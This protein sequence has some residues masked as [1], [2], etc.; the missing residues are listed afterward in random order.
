MADDDVVPPRGRKSEDLPPTGWMGSDDAS[1]QVVKIHEAVRRRAVA[2]ITEFSTPT[3]LQAAA[4]FAGAG[5]LSTDAKVVEAVGDTRRRLEFG[6]QLAE[7]PAE[8][9]DAAHVLAQTVKE[10]ITELRA[11]RHND[12]ESADFIDFLEMIARE[13][14]RLVDALDRAIAAKGSADQQQM[15][16]GEAG[17]IANHLKAG[18]YEYLEQHRADIAG[19]SIKVGLVSAAAWFL[20]A[21]G[22]DLASIVSVFKK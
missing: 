3:P 9:R 18:F 8:I 7:R 15:F 6:Q 14:D 1:N 21:C 10:Q 13:L 19:H 22:F 16:L 5:S 4:A 12:T 17:K 2:G 11:A 20:H